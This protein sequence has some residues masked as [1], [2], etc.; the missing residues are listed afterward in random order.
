MIQE[1]I[2]LKNSVL[3]I[4]SVAIC[5][6]LY[7]VYLLKTYSK[8]TSEDFHDLSSDYDQQKDKP[9]EPSV[10][11]VEDKEEK[12]STLSKKK[13]PGDSI[14]KEL[15]YFR[16]LGYFFVNENA[17]FV[18]VFLIFA[19]IAMIISIYWLHWIVGVSFL[20]GYTEFL[21]TFYL[22]RKLFVKTMTRMD[23]SQSNPQTKNKNWQYFL[24]FI[25]SDLL[26]FN[27]SA[28]IISTFTILL[29]FDHTFKMEGSQFY[30]RKKTMNV[31][32]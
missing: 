9:P 22:C 6:I 14:K 30:E 7:T 13:Q 4:Y 17:Y 5:G 15:I 29:I 20:F 24:R 10:I 16:E 21:L 31:Y 25:T 23:L 8:H 32:T 28:S 3:A 12:L 19:P 18:L 1:A 2:V 11:V 26:I 27:M